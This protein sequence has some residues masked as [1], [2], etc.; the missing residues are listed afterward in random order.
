MI[1][2]LV[3]GVFG[4]LVVSALLHLWTMHTHKR[5]GSPNWTLLNCINVLCIVA[6]LLSAF[7]LFKRGSDFRA[8][9]PLWAMLCV[10]TLV[11]FFSI[12]GVSIVHSLL[13]DFDPDSPLPVPPTEAEE[14]PDIAYPK[15]M[16]SLEVLR[17]ANVQ[18]SRATTPSEAW[19]HGA[20]LWGLTNSGSVTVDMLRE[21]Q[22]GRT[23]GLFC[24]RTC[25]RCGS[26]EWCLLMSSWRRLTVQ[27]IQRKGLRHV[28]NGKRSRPPSPPYMP[29]IPE[30]PECAS[31]CSSL[32]TSDTDLSGFPSPPTSPMSPAT[33]RWGSG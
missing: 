20:I 27:S 5:T 9:N 19:G 30:C 16:E 1:L 8:F 32:D 18:V 23:V 6:F 15:P 13:D 31:D 24:K 7:Q 29:S 17:N 2:S 33:C 4:S 11:Y 25:G 10:V 22:I 12:F 21:T 28:G 14:V 3:L 26:C